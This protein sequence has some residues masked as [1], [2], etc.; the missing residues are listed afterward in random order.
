MSRIVSPRSTSTEM[1]RPSPAGAISLDISTDSV[2]IEYPPLSFEAGDASLR[3]GPRFVLSILT[4]SRRPTEWRQRVR[5]LA[6][7]VRYRIIPKIMAEAPPWST[8]LRPRFMDSDSYEFGA[9]PRSLD[10][11]RRAIPYLRH[12]RETP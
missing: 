4:A 6:P 12:H 8:R 10:G 11:A 1:I 2:V 9:R 7:K 5:H 3:P